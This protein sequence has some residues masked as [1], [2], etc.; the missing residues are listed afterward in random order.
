MSALAIFRC[1]LGDVFKDR[2][3]V[4]ALSESYHKCWNEMEVRAW[5]HVCVCMYGHT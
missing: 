5:V 3:E 4:E 2:A 1:C